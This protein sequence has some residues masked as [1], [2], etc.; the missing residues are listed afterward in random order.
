MS[1]SRTILRFGGGYG[2]AVIIGGVLSI[3]VIP[4]VILAAG[5]RSWATIA[6]AQAVGGFAFVLVAAG[7]GVTGPTATA[8]L[9]EGERGRFYRDSVA[10]RSW[11][12]LIFVGPSCLLAV[13]LTDQP[14][15]A[16]MTVAG[17][18]LAALSAGWFYVGES[19]PVRFLI[20][21]TLPRNLA[22][23][24]GALILLVTG[25]ALWFVTAQFLGALV[26]AVVATIDIA[27]RYP[28]DGWSIGPIASLRRLRGQSSAITMAATAAVYVNLPIVVVQVFVPSATAVY[29]LAERIMRMALYATRPF[30]QFS[31]GYVP[32]PD[33]AQQ[34]IRAS[35]VSALAL[36]SGV[37][38]GAAYA[39]A[40][41][42]VSSVLSGGT[43]PMSLDLSIPMGLALAAMLG[44]QVTG[45]ACLTAFGLTRTLAQSTV[46]GAILAALALIPA[47]LVLGVVGVAWVLAMSELAVLAVQLVKLR[48]YFARHFVRP[49]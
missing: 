7:W 30:V 38:G 33:P 24:V 21:D 40:G 22:T 42:L 46:V 15:L 11:L 44:S 28:A 12:F 16:A 1:R 41:P 23:V 45:F 18:M 6:V 2:L 36:A 9:D 31:Q 14:W 27:R 13:L 25:E 20:I 37:L 5:E 39:V 49:N 48:P 4:V 17:G 32:H 19:S 3:A 34:A 35:R 8:A 10:T 43:L 26:A 29:A 47:A